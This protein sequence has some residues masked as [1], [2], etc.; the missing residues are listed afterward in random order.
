MIN[1]S[2]VYHNAD[3]VISDTFHLLDAFYRSQT[4]DERF[5]FGVVIKHDDQVSS[6][7]SVVTVDVDAA[8]HELFL[9]GDDARQIVDNSDV[10]DADDAQRDAVL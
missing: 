1:R 10:V 5:E 2:S 4:L 6:E 7:Q 8:Q 9:L 3:C